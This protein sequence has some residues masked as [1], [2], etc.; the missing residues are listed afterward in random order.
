[1]QAVLQTLESITSEIRSW[2]DLTE[3][4]Q[5]QLARSLSHCNQIYWVSPATIEELGAVVQC[6]HRNQWRI[7]PCG[8]ATKLNW[9]GVV[10]EVSL[11]VSTEKLDRVIEHAQGDLT[12][13][14]EVGISF[15]ELQAIVGKAG[16][17][18]AIDPKFSDRAT[19][20][21]IIATADSGSLRH[22]YNSVRDML[23]G[24]T[25]VR[26]D[27][28]I[29]KAGGRVVKNVAGYD[30]MKLLTGSYGTLGILAQATLRVYPIP[31][32]TGA[33]LVYGDSD[34]LAQATQTLLSS[35][36]TPTRVDLISGSLT[37]KST[38]GLLVQFQSIPE[39]VNLQIERLTEVATTLGLSVLAADLW[40]TLHDRM[41]VST[42]S[43]AIVCKIGVKPSFAVAVLD[44]LESSLPNAEVVIHA[45]SGIGYLNVTGTRSTQ[46]LEARSLCEASGGYLSVLQA[47]IAF[48]Q[49]LDI[50]GYS[51]NALNLMQRVKSQFD[52]QTLF[53][54]HRFVG[55]I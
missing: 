21:G 25:F 17:F 47:P 43:D 31:A 27:G 33:L 1:M 19:L 35:A 24:I 18:C 12:V 9:G 22:R 2:S 7:L 26:Y 5:A 20:G 51:G 14:T 28:E 30:L 42:Q 39:S 11:V 16:Q 3:F 34:S 50:W 45:G 29:V 53:S 13:T 48:K 44:Q 37:G 38:I 32:S 49:Q 52:P 36:L 55:G 15:A 41:N 40:Q 46:I 23:L 54:P 6:A 8:H 4:Q 10:D